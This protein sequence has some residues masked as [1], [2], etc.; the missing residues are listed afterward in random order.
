[1]VWAKCQ[2]LLNEEIGFIDFQFELS[3]HQSALATGHLGWDGVLLID[4]ITFMAGFKI[5]WD[6]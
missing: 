5:G 4:A 2:L 6:S 1:M 3:I